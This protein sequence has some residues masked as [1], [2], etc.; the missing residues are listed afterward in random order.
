MQETRVCNC[1]LLLKK[2]FKTLAFFQKMRYYKFLM[3]NRNGYDLYF[4]ASN[5]NH[6]D[7]GGSTFHEE[8]SNFT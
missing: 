2:R 3:L 1:S 5:K 7:L 8:N 6:F 4:S